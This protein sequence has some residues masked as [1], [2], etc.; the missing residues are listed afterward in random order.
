[1]NNNGEHAKRAVQ[2]ESGGHNI[3]K[4]K[5]VVDKS[6][7]RSQLAVNINTK[8]QACFE[9]R[10]YT[11]NINNNEVNFIRS[12]AAAAVRELFISLC[13]AI[14]G[15]VQ[16]FSGKNRDFY[17]FIKQKW[18]IVCILR[19]IRLMKFGNC[20]WNRSRKSLNVEPGTWCFALI[21]ILP[22][23]QSLFA[24]QEM[25]FAWLIFADSICKNVCLGGQRRCH[26]SPAEMHNW[27]VSR[28]PRSA[29][30]FIFSIRLTVI[31]SC[32]QMSIG[33]VSAAECLT[34]FG[35]FVY[36]LLYLRSR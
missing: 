11:N 1:M 21:L 12:P 27:F 5:W 22:L 32:P 4:M 10:A 18:F 8:C 28:S 36:S 26:V 19:L 34:H 15:N 14:R 6:E 30:S 33:H 17:E 23:E 3:Y 25:C 16:M 2:G 24:M 31:F 7:A 9:R 13:H 20:R 29:R 35:V